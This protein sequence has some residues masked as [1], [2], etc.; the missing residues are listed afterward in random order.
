[1]IANTRKRDRT[2]GSRPRRLDMAF[3]ASRSQRS[4]SEP[5]SPVWNDSVAKASR[6]LQQRAERAWGYG[7]QVIAPPVNFYA[8]AAFLQINT[9]H[10]RACRVKAEVSTGEL[11]IIKPRDSTADRDS[12]NPGHARFLRGL[13][14][15]ANE[16]ESLSAVLF[17]V[18]FDLEALGNAYLEVVRDRVGRPVEL[19]HIPAVGVRRGWGDDK[20][21][22][23]W[24]LDHRFSGRRVFFKDFGDDRAMRIDGQPADGSA[25]EEQ[26][27]SELIHLRCYVP[28]E[29]YYG[30]PEWLTAL[31]GMEGTRAAEEWNADRFQHN[32][33]PRKIITFIGGEQDDELEATIED[34]FTTV[35]KGRNHRPLVLFATPVDGMEMGDARIQVDSLETEAQDAGFLEYQNQNRDQVVAAHGVP[36]ALM[37]V[38]AAGRLGGKGA[39]E[40]QRRDFKR[41]VVVPRQRRLEEILNERLIADTEHGFGITDWVLRLGDFDLSDQTF[42]VAKAEQLRKLVSSGLL[43]ANEARQELGL[44][45][46]QDLPAADEPMVMQ[47]GGG[48]FLRQL[49]P[50][51]ELEAPAVAPTPDQTEQAGQAG[52]QTRTTEGAAA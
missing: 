50:T 12:L 33:I 19:H 8:L 22:G 14:R 39:D 40:M 34:Y 30:L 44:D 29:Q 17:K 37:G 26:L 18:E 10:Q 45:P 3:R 31:I 21:D 4:K 16:D 35:A 41:L 20:P 38:Q 23:F 15:Q 48:I 46:F 47:P 5:V 32:T 25:A 49:D 13:V 42:S 2:K 9:W 52:G 28:T 43:T 1:M 51:A 36:P 7:T 27:A 11:A 6:Q 24:Q